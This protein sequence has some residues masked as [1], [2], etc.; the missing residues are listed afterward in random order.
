[1][2]QLRKQSVKGCP[3]SPICIFYGFHKRAGLT[4]RNISPSKHVL[5][6]RSLN[7]KIFKRKGII[8]EGLRYSTCIQ[9]QTIGDVFLSV[10]HPSLFFSSN[11]RAFKIIM[12]YGNED[13]ATVPRR[14]H[15][16]SFFLHLLLI[17]IILPLRKGKL[18]NLVP[19]KVYIYQLL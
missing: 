4:C 5:K 13:F 19:K 11:R 9:K 10:N 16:L 18:W 15:F 8:F 14:L 1:M 12:M 3:P 2:K 7:K 6:R 17:H